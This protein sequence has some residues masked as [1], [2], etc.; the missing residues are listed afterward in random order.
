M[1]SSKAYNPPRPFNPHSS[2]AGAWN[3]EYLASAAGPLV[4][5]VATTMLQDG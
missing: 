5:V 2:E 1:P 4:L 3:L